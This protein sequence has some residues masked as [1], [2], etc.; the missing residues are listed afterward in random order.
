LL[1][2]NG[3]TT[4]L[5]DF[6]GTLRHSFPLPSDFF[7]DYVLSRGHSISTDDRRRGARWE[8]YYWASSSELQADL[9]L[10]RDEKEEFWHQYA[11][12]RLIV[13]GLDVV[14]AEA[15]A[16]EVSQYMAES[17]KRED[18][19]PTEIP[20]VLE[21]LQKAGYRMGVVSNRDKPYWEELVTLDLCPFF[22]FS[23]A[24]GEVQ[25]WKPEPGIFQSALERLD[26]TA[27]QTIY[28]GD[29]YFADVVGAHR[30]G[31]QPVLYDPRG[32]FHDPGCP[33]ITNFDEL[34][35]VVQS[36]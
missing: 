23:L 10:F 8:H 1:S 4:I 29:N 2:P 34:P 14:T 35:K 28:V 9:N 32:I 7:S 18:I 24:A 25:S 15:F 17:Y 27:T 13:L 26:A 36:T 19:V 3:I 12:R 30:A 22:E 33:V 11:F 21:M 20:G 31:L 16:P 6:D 5:F